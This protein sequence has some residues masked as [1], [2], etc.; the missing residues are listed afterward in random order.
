LQRK[1]QS[2][3]RRWRTI[4]TRREIKKLRKKIWRARSSRKRRNSGS[5]RISLEKLYPKKHKK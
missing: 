3:V 1:L 5:W 4:R 2:R